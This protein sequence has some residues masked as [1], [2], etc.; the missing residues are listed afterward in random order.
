M[1]DWLV[2]GGG[3]HGT[4]LAHVLVN[5][6]GV[7]A[8]ALRILDPHADLLTSWNRRT[9]NT[10]MR[11]LRS[12][13]V[14]HIDLE[15]ESLEC[16]ARERGADDPVAWIVP[17]HRPSYELFQRHCQH[18]IDTCQLDR[19]HMRG[20]ALA[21]YR[22]PNGWRVETADGSVTAQQI[23][24]ATG[25]QQL[26]IP[27]WAELMLAEHVLLQHV[28]DTAFDRQR[29]PDGGEIVVIGGGISAGQ[30][31]LDLVSDNHNVT[32]ITR[33]PLRQHDFDSSPCWLGP[34]CLNA[35][36]QSNYQRRR[37]MIGEARQPGTLPQD[38]YKDLNT[39]I[40]LERINHSQGVVIAGQMTSDNRIMLRLADNS[41]LAADHVVLAT[42]LKAVPPTQT[43]LADAITRYDLPVADC[44]YPV[45]DQTLCWSPGLYATGPLAELELGPSAA[46]IAGARAAG[47]RLQQTN[48]TR[49]ILMG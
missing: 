44:G 8:D 38:V 45:L 28:L 37:W 16:F 27:H 23:L 30:I 6:Q 14:H 36:G 1:L 35:F 7:P 33:Q 17:Y 34:A 9:A 40:R 32:L 13:R 31:A 47:V 26:N 24:L 11:Y 15:P 22:V 19:L 39:A 42:G 10:G 43:W 25:R 2:I 29:I 3:I 5:R 18:V 12:P 46:N 20:Q 4:H 41:V 49:S 21:L 48:P